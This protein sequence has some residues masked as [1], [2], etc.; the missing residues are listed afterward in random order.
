M[1][2]ALHQ[3]GRNRIKPPEE[4]SLLGQPVAD[5]DDSYRVSPGGLMVWY[6]GRV[7]ALHH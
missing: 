3:A 4:T 5:H 1:G 2:F 7:A 6:H